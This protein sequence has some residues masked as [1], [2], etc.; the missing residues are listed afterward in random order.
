MIHGG[1]VIYFLDLKFYSYKN[2]LRNTWIRSSIQWREFFI[3]PYL[4]K[5]EAEIGLL[6]NI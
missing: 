5:L 1:R 6:T 2:I 3:P 4:I